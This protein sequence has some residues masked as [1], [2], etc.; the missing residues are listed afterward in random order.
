MDVD[1][2]RA[3][4]GIGNRAIIGG[5]R[6]D[7]S[8]RRTRHRLGAREYF[9]GSVGGRGVGGRVRNV[10]QYSGGG[11]FENLRARS[12]HAARESVE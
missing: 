2:G 5:L 9:C 10:A 11:M 4:V 7:S 6:F 3:V 1:R 8:D 12:D